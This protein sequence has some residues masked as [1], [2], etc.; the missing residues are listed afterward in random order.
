MLS[1]HFAGFPSGPIL[2]HPK[3]APNSNQGRS[4]VGILRRPTPEGLGRHAICPFALRVQ[5]DC[6]R[7]RDSMEKKITVLS[8]EAADAAVLFL[9]RGPA[10]WP[11]GSPTDSP[12]HLR[13]SV[14]YLLCALA[15]VGLAERDR[16]SVIQIPIIS[17]LPRAAKAG[18][19]VLSSRNHMDCSSRASRDAREI[20]SGGPRG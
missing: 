17:P 19:L 8:A 12:R 11:F 13:S 16:G 7:A 1:A 2:M 6:S 5:Q 3:R 4:A 10:H 15:L 20:M 18:L 14:V 9:R